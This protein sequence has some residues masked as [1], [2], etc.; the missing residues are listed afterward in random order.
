MVI[1]FS[2]VISFVRSLPERDDVP[3]EAQFTTDDAVALSLLKVMIV[4]E[5]SART[6]ARAALAHPFVAPYADPADEPDAPA[7]LELEHDLSS[8]R[9]YRATEWRAVIL[10]EVQGE[11]SEIASRIADQ[12]PR[13]PCTRCS[14]WLDRTHFRACYPTS[15]G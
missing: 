3:F 4:F 6:T 8:D 15:P 12:V 5:P 13:F 11:Y 2:Q 14:V 7:R 10:A 1:D 9:E